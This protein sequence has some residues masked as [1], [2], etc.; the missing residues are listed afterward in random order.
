MRSLLSP[1]RQPPEGSG[2]MPG[3]LRPALTLPAVETDWCALTEIQGTLRA[4]GIVAET[5]EILNAILAALAQRPT[6]CRGL[7]AAYLLGG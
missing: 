1:V 3:L 6:L 7:L 5:P 4:H 2:P